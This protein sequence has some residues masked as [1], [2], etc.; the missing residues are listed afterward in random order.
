MRLSGELINLSGGLAFILYKYL[1]SIA[2]D[3]SFLK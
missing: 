3:L 1:L 2:I